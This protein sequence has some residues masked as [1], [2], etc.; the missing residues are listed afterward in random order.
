[1]CLFQSMYGVDLHQLYCTREYLLIIWRQLSSC[2]EPEVHG[3]NVDTATMGQFHCESSFAKAKSNWSMDVMCMEIYVIVS[4]S[5]QKWGGYVTHAQPALHWQ[6]SPHPQLGLPHPDKAMVMRKGEKWVE[7]LEVQ[8][9]ASK[10]GGEY[11]EARWPVGC[12]SDF[13]L[14]LLGYV[15]HPMVPL[16]TALEDT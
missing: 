9:K 3:Y 4:V 1:M 14:F 13:I 5:K 15:P 12:G 10:Q 11:N 16:G 2:K 7:E 6:L 8:R